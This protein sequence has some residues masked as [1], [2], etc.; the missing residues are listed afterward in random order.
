M[1]VGRSVHVGTPSENVCVCLS[2][3]LWSTSQIV[4]KA[5]VC[6]YVV[7]VWRLVVS[8]CVCVRLCGC[9]AAICVLAWYLAYSVNVSAPSN[10]HSGYVCVSFLVVSGFLRISFRICV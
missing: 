3:V 7:G 2:V 1:L 8:G 4:F 6:V 5:F 10:Y 9:M